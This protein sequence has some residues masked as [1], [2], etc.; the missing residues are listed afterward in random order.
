MTFPRRFPTLAALTATIVSSALVCDPLTM[1]AVGSGKVYDTAAIRAAVNAC[2]AAG[3]GTVIFRAGYTFLTG[4]FNVSNNTFVQVDGTILGSPNS[5]GYTLV[6][7][8]PWYGPDPPQKVNDAA[9]DPREWQPLISSWYNSNVSIAGS[10]VIDGQGASWWG[11]ASNQSAPP[12]DGYPR[13]H[14]IRFVGGSHFEISG[15][16]IMNSPMWQARGRACVCDGRG[17][18]GFALP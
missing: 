17:G 3:G 12:C 5:T 10:G 16:S 8:L 1:G 2:G 4:A 18:G 15:V 6:D 13:P 7:P 9:P 14:M 11:C